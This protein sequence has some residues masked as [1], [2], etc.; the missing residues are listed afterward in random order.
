M[1]PL[2]VCTTHRRAPPPAPGSHLLG[3]SSRG[4]DNRVLSQ[5]SWLYGKVSHDFP[6]PGIIITAK[7]WRPREGRWLGP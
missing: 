3:L 7:Q 2:A 4:D 6:S 5:P 1:L